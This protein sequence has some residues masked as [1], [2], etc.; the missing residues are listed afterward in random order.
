MVV[1]AQRARIWRNGDFLLLWVGLL[2]SNLGDWVNYIAMYAV[3]YQ[4]THSPLALVGLRLIHV[5]PEFLFGPFA[6]VFVDRWSRKTTLRVSALASSGFVALLVFAHPA[7]LI[8]VAEAAITLAAMF[9]EPAVS[10]AMPN[11][12][13]EE[14][15]VQ[16]NTLARVTSIL[17]TVV[18]ALIGG[19]LVSTVGGRAAFGFDAVSFLVIGALLTGVQVREEVIY[20]P[21][22]TIERELRE[23]LA[24]LRQQPVVAAVVAAGAVFVLP[25]S[26][27]FTVGIVFSQSVLRAG[28]TGYGVILA[29]G[30]AGSLIAAGWLILGHTRARDDLLFAATGVIQGGAM[31]FMGLSHSLVLA[32]TLYGI[33]D[34]MSTVSGVSRLTL[35][36]R[37]VPD[38]LRGRIFGVASS[39]THLVALIDALLVAAGIGLLGAGGL[40][41]ASG[42]AAVAAGLFVLGALPYA[43][44]R[45]ESNRLH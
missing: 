42:A 38:A 24:Y 14:D 18:G 34:G 21:A 4:Q 8:F 2:I 13:R 26:T 3:L 40:I 16:A 10:A 28:A 7:V 27:I 45:L 30:G 12:V 23:G 31:V 29:A 19:V 35:V 11:I 9:F 44:K 33:A 15:L 36:Q 41:T 32:A 1:S 37:L 5:A 43:R 6:G 25:T 20:L 22:T 17:A 39:L